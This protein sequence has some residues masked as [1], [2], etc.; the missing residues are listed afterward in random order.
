MTISL[1]TYDFRFS[2]KKQSRVS[3]CMA[4]D[5][6]FVWFPEQYLPDVHLTTAFTAMIGLHQYSFEQCHCC[7]SDPPC[8]LHQRT[9]SVILQIRG[10][11]VRGHVTWHAGMISTSAY[12]T[13]SGA[14]PH[15]THSSKSWK[16]QGDHST[17]RH[18]PGLTS[19][20]IETPS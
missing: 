18:S 6:N 15:L 4:H 20:S 1:I 16:H 13:L 12:L 5:C 2:Q 3:N 10:W 11:H 8:I 9:Q 17:E 19:C 7:G 14:L